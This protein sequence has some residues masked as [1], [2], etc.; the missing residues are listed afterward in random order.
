ML[1]I[2]CAS[3][4]ALSIN[5]AK[6][7]ETIDSAVIQ[8]D[9]LLNKKHFSN[10]KLYASDYRREVDTRERQSEERRDREE[11]EEYQS[12]YQREA[13]EAKEEHRTEFPDEDYEERDR[14]RRGDE[15]Y[16]EDRRDRH[17]DYGERDRSRED[18]EREERRSFPDLIENWLSK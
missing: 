3:C 18:Y 14:Q 8:K 15:E 17:E 6:G 9:V 1:E 7:I 12:D 11:P 13:D 16:T 4:M 2:I 10:G 5:I